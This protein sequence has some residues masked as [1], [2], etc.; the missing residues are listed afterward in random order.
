MKQSKTMGER[1]I[2]AY[3]KSVMKN[4]DK[5]DKL[6]QKYWNKGD[7]C[8]YKFWSNAASGFFMRSVSPQGVDMRR[9]CEAMNRRTEMRKKYTRFYLLKLAFLKLIHYY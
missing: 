1:I 2:K 7:V 3:N 9:K 8:M 4:M 6:K 5:A